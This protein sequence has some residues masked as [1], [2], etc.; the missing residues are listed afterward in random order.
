MP[1]CVFALSKTM[2]FVAFLSQNVKFHATCNVQRLCSIINVF[3]FKEPP[4]CLLWCF[5][6]SNIFLFCSRTHALLHVSC[7]L[8]VFK[9]NANKAN[10]LTNV[11]FLRHY[12]KFIKMCIMCLKIPNL[13]KN[14]KSIFFYN[15]MSF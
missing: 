11:N 5:F 3:C 10:K 9:F 2:S 6:E 15:M 4:I 8:L 12:T 13:V 1:F 7:I 14:P